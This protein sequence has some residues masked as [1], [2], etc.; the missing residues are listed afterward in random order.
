[1]K[2]IFS[3]SLYTALITLS[4]DLNDD[5]V[6]RFAAVAVEDALSISVLK[7]Q[8]KQLEIQWLL[9]EEPDAAGLEAKIILAAA[10]FGLTQEQD[11]DLRIAPV[12]DVN[13]LEESYRQFAPFRVGDFYICGTHSTPQPQ[14]H[15]M[16]LIIDAATAFGSGEHGTTSGCLTLL[17]HLKARGDTPD[18]ILDL[19]CGS[20][21]LAVAACK[22]WNAPVL[23]T[24][25][26]DE[27]VR[28]SNHHKAV[29][30]IGDQLQT[31]AGDGFAVIEDSY[32]LI[33]ANILAGPL[34]DMAA[35]LAGHLR[36]RGYVILSG[37]LQEQED[38]L[39]AVYL[40]LGLRLEETCHNGEWSALL[41]RKATPL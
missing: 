36:D 35:D 28:V 9:A 10:A 37:L 12:P 40:P 21:I 18:N 4:A 23:A 13:W 6:S 34:K 29:N 3:P 19:G 20:G 2:T 31:L 27:C 30:G 14:P 5:Q 32:D 41:L 24:D 39:L 8:K 16:T 33:I 26:D 11:F 1:M 22:L 15:E 38:D 25:I 7:T 17:Q